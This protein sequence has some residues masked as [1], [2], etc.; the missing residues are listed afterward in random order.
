MRQAQEAPSYQ[1]RPVFE[2]EPFKAVTLKP[3]ILQPFLHHR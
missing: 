1:W 3:L 2:L